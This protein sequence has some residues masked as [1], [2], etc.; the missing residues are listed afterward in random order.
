M[1][2]Q[3]DTDRI[4]NAFTFPGLILL[5][6][7]T[8]RHPLLFRNLISLVTSYPKH[9]YSVTAMDLLLFRQGEQKI[10]HIEAHENI[11]LLYPRLKAGFYLGISKLKE[12]IAVTQ[13][14]VNNS[15]HWISLFYY[16]KNVYWFT[17]RHFVRHCSSIYWFIIIRSFTQVEIIDFNSKFWICTTSYKHYNS[18]LHKIY[19]WCSKINYWIIFKI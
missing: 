8:I 19:F 10:K 9:N 15:T 3:W 16:P 18:A 6:F 2:Q 11:I 5:P 7:S 4:T 13:S 1:V 14:M 12:S 17:C